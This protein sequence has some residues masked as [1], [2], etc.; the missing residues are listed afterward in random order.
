MHNNEKTIYGIRIVPYRDNNGINFGMFEGIVISCSLSD[1]DNI[2]I[3]K[4]IKTKQGYFV[5]SWISIPYEDVIAHSN[6]SGKAKAEFLISKAKEF[7]KENEKIAICDTL[8]PHL[9]LKDIA[10]EN[11]QKLLKEQH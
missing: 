9:E 7:A 4:L 8:V 6:T 5:H 2:E 10:W 11:L 3:A 1:F